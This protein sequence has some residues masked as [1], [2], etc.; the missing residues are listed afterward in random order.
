MGN[1]IGFYLI[2]IPI[3]ICRFS[4]FDLKS[5]YMIVYQLMVFL[6]KDMKWE[7]IVINN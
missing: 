2:Y 6:I 3:Y 4:P 7:Y 1:I 5:K